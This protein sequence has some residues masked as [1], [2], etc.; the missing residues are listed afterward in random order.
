MTNVK[1]NFM[2]IYNIEKTLE[3]REK[4]INEVAKN[5]E[6]IRNK[7]MTTIFEIQSELVTVDSKLKTTII[8]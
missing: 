1:E 3:A 7:S 8:N 6:I 2:T 4:S 5:M